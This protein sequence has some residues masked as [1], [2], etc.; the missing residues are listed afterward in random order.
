MNIPQSAHTRLSPSRIRS[1]LICGLGLAL[2]ASVALAQTSGTWTSTTGGNWA[3]IV[4]WNSGAGPVATG[5]STSANVT[6]TF[7]ASGTQTVNLDGPQTVQT[8][9]FSTGTYTLSSTNGSVLTLAGTTV[10]S[11]SGTATI[12]ATLDGSQG[13][14]YAS[15]NRTLTLSGN[16]IYT[17]VTTLTN[18]N[19]TARSDSAFG[20]AGA[21]NGLIVSQASG[22]FPQLHLTN[23]ITTSEDITLRM[24]FYNIANNGSIVGGNLLYNDNSN[25]TLNGSLVLDRYVGSNAN[26]VHLMGIQASG[27]TLTING[28]VSGAAT[29][30]QASG[31][32][33]DPTRLQFRAT[34][35]TAN[36][37]VTG[38]ISDGTLT[39][40]GLSIYTA[41]DAL[42]IVRLSGDNTYTGSTVHQKGTLLINNTT[43]SGTGAGAISV[44]STAVFGGTGFVKPAGANGI[45]FAS[46]S[47][48]SPGD[49]TSGGSAIAAGKTLTFDLS[50]TTG[51]ALFDTG[52]TI[53]I[54]LNAAAILPADVSEHLAFIGLTTGV[55]QVTF[56]NNIVNFSITGGLLSN[57]V[58]TLASFSADNA[59]SGQ[60]VL[61]SGLEAYN[62]QLIQTANSIQL[63]ISAI[64]EPAT[65]AALA[66]LIAIGAVMV[67]KRRRI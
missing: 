27:G 59:F 10:P 7:S 36:V 48:V 55:S 18:G 61:G 41:A 26:V 9:A 35:A 40:G 25:T 57:G 32:Y 4:N 56:N 46:G 28:A 31:T 2:P 62:A 12:S 39:T 63:S 67:C 66:G 13:F 49:L 21:G 45:T 65:T 42:G 51:T 14:T 15:G 38:V 20:A 53:A 17:G 33:V 11:I 43:G 34:T 50:S 58:Y 64:P 23:N 44:A 47:I 54:N 22:Q 19:L 24:N 3:D 52:S 60:W 8:L 16:N 5:G 1:A 29:G 6:A 30:G 37:N